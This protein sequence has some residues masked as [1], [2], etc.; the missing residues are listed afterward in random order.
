MQSMELRA[1][2]ELLPALLAL[3]ETESVTRA[4]QRMHVGQPAMSRTLEKL[5]EATGDDLLVRSGRRLVI[6]RRA[7]E[8][9]PEVR[10]TLASAERVLAPQE[11]FDPARARGSVTLALGDDMQ[12]ILASRLLPPLRAAAPGVDVRVRP[13]SLES[14]QEAVRGLVDLAVLPD[15]R[16]QYPIPMIDEL[17]MAP[18]YDRRFVT[19]AARPR[20]FTLERFLEAEHVL[21]SPRGDETGYV[22][23]ALRALGRRRRIAVT[24]PSFQAAIAIVRETELVATLPD[25]VVRCLAP[26]LRRTA[27]PVPTPEF[28]MCV[29]WASRFTKDA[30]HRW[31][32]A[33]VA[34][35]VRPIGR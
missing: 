18:Q 16:N 3:L 7:A 19:V 23:D 11:S 30:R 33:L 22:D 4:A 13:L 24:V 9:L 26:E 5:R 21:V 17:V 2:V 29:A 34:E 28:P 27:C 8:I 12:A 35:V 15:L 32:R 25:D 1:P 31:L 10:A 20:R 14:A 6:T